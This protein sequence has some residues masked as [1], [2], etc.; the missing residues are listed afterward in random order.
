MSHVSD[1]E[2]PIVGDIDAVLLA[3]PWKCTPEQ[4][5]SC[6]QLCIFDFAFEGAGQEV[7][8]DDPVRIRSGHPEDI[9]VKAPGN[10]AD[11]SCQRVGEV[12][13]NAM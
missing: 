3:E 6:F 5:D 8:H 2:L 11:A 7:N 4:G 9:Q 1:R 12:M 10:E 13:G